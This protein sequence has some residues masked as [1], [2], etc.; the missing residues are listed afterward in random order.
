M[1]PLEWVLFGGLVIAYVLHTRLLGLRASRLRE[2][3]QDAGE[4]STQAA[5]WRAR[6]LDLG[7]DPGEYRA[8]HPRKERD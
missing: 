4:A 5:F 8:A 7:A 1:T 2:D 6:A 3:A